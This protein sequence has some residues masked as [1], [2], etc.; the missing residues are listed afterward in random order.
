M[1]KRPGFKTCR[2][3]VTL[4]ACY[5]DGV[6]VSQDHSKAVDWYRKAIAAGNTVAMITLGDCYTTGAGVQED[7]AKAA[8]WYEKAAQAGEPRVLSYLGLRY[9]NG[10]GVPK[11]ER[12]AVEWFQK[13]AQSG[14]ASAMGTSACATRTDKAFSRADRQPWIGT[15]RE[16]TLETR[17]RCSCSEMCS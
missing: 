7:E 3:A 12:K 10:T 8:E 1:R 11:N 16:Q 17:I 15:R 9:L 13:A 14:D 4:G 5:S 6:L 2:P